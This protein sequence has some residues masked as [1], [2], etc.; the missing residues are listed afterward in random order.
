MKGRAVESAQ[1]TI[2]NSP[3]IHRWESGGSFKS[4]QRTAE[5]LSPVSRALVLLMRQ[6]PS[7]EV[8]G[9]YRSSAVRT[10]H[11]RQT[12]AG[13]SLL[14][15]ISALTVTACQHQIARTRPPLKPPEQDIEV[16]A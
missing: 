9:Y 10:N 8:L 3:A 15:I 6:S 14:L 1:R 5:I 2:G 12:N 7:T 13:L 16:R 11:L 4:A